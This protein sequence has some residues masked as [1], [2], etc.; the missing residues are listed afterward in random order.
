LEYL[1]YDGKPLLELS[2]DE[3]FG[4]IE[5]DGFFGVDQ[6]AQRA[7]DFVIGF[8][9]DDVSL[10]QEGRKAIV[11]GF[12]EAEKLWGGK[13][14]NIAYETQEKIL[15]AIDETIALLGGNILNLAV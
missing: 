4:L 1:D 12:E 13:L 7:S 2:Q 3:A 9:G 6:S 10:L 11:E 5:S 15:Q 14:A 8:A